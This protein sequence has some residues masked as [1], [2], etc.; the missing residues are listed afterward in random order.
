[1][2]GGKVISDDDQKIDSVDD[3]E[4]VSESWKNRILAQRKADQEKI[5]EMNEKLESFESEKKKIEEE[6]LKQEGNWK[7]LL[8]SRERTLQELQDKL[9]E[10]DEAV[11]SYETHLQ[12]AKKLQGLQDALGGKF[13][14]PEYMNLVD[15][16]KIAVDPDTGNVDQSSLKSYADH[17]LKEHKELIQF[18]KP[19]INDNAPGQSLSMSYDEWVKLAQTN[20]KEAREKMH[21]VK[22]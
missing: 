2:E 9:N 11:K 15:T 18:N 4:K 7:E 16:S 20:P 3:G 5:R 12:E 19:Q 14:K 10:K 8:E 13:R 6:K 1:M 17:F 22:K 21:L